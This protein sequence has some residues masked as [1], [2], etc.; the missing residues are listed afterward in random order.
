MPG[1]PVQHITRPIVAGA[2]YTVRCSC[3]TA[4]DMKADNEAAALAQFRA[5]HSHVGPMPEL[6]LVASRIDYTEHPLYTLNCPTCGVSYAACRCEG[7]D[8]AA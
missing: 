4:V 6:T 1:E 8:H 2:N 3:G 5:R 7:D